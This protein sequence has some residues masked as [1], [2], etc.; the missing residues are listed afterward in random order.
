MPEQPVEI[1]DKWEGPKTYAEDFY[2][3]GDIRTD[4]PAA[5]SAHLLPGDLDGF[6]HLETIEDDEDEGMAGLDFLGN[7]S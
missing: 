7:I 6:P 1:L 5:G 3:G 2:S 4:A